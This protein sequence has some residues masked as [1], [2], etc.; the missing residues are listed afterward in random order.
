MTF[1][2]AVDAIIPRT[3]ELGAE[4]GDEHVPGAA[5]A[6]VEDY[7]ITYINN[8]FSNLNPEGDRSGNLRLSEPV[9]GL[10]DQAAT[11]LVA[12][13]GNGDPPSMSYTRDLLDRST[14]LDEA[15]DAAASGPFA[16]LSRGD[17]LRALAQFD[18]DEKTVDTAAFPGPMTE[19]NTGLLATLV[20]AF[21]EVIYYSEWDGYDEFRQPPSDRQ[22]DPDAVQSFEQTGFQGFIDGAAALRG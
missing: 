16:R 15:V 10:L 6:G 19:W 12:E 11:E 17:R 2:A 18:E 21:T 7:L 20:V 8:L 22:F 3:P 13:G 4:L 1:A 5:A 14:T 9:A